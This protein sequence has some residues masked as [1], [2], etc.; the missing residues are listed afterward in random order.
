MISAVSM[1]GN[2][3]EKNELDKYQTNTIR[4]QFKLAVRYTDIY[5]YI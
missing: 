2:Q 3:F 1:P 4:N 5:I